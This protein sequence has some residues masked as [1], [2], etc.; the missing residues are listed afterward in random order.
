MKQSVLARRSTRPL[1]LWLGLIVLAGG[2]FL[3]DVATPLEVSVSVLYVVVVLLASLT[4]SRQT[5]LIVA[6]VCLALSLLSYGLS[7]GNPWDYWPLFD[8]I[9]GLSGLIACTLLAMWSLSA[10][11]AARRS[12]DDLQQA[13][14][15]LARITRATTMGQLAASIAH[16]I[17]QPLTGVVTN[18]Q[19]VLH[20]LKEETRDLDRARITAERIVRDGERASGVIQRIQ[21][22]LTKTPPQSKE[23]DLNQ[24]IGEVLALVQ[25]ELRLRQVVVQ[26]ELAPAPVLV[27]GDTV[28]LQQVLLNL[29]VN[30]ADAMSAVTDR[31]RILVIGSRP[32]LNG[33]GTVFV[34]DYGT[35]LDQNTVDKIFNPFFTTKSKGMGMGL[36]IC[37]SIIAAHGG[38]LWAEPAEPYG[39]LFQFTV[40]NRAI[41][42]L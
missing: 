2:I 30:G 29:V 40:P 17:N 4:H 14:A 37:Q 32:P 22:L 28:Q 6:L 24:L 36:A 12:M 11:E 19:T 13:Q 42:E 3:V 16:E 23:V 7:P 31:G 41:E 20:W 21:A 33:E 38:R 39:A 35:G 10:A 26:T 15:D 8:R 9:V 27:L 18:G 1:L 34:R 5:V 25:T